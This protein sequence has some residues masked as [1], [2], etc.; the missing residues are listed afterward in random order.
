MSTPSSTPSAGIVLRPF[1]GVEHEPGHA[2]SRPTGH[3]T[4]DLPAH[5]CAVCY[6]RWQRPFCNT[7][8]FSASDLDLV[9]PEDNDR[10]HKARGCCDG[11]LPHSDAKD[12]SEGAS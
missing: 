1:C 10:V 3:V 7:W 9:L 4:S 8:P 11:W 2:C 5:R 12:R 6:L